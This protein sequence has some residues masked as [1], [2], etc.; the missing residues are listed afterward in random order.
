VALLAVT[1][2]VR[3]SHPS[4]LQGED[5]VLGQPMEL[6]RG[7]ALALNQTETLAA[8]RRGDRE[9]QCRLGLWLLREYREQGSRSS[10]SEGVDWLRQAAEGGEP[11]AQFELGNLHESGSGVIQDFAEA[12]HWYREAAQR[13]HFEAM[14]CLGRLAGLGRGVQK[15]LVDAY[16]W[17][18]VAAARGEARAEPAR[19]RVG[20]LLS[21]AE[22]AEAQERSR[23][24]HA[25]IPS[26]L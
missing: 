21:A 11:E 24:L 20:A 10:L 7:T 26:R 15:D 16:A 1:A 18:N 4:S 23:Q 3:S 17:L 8:A 9:A 2:G 14:Y 25:S 12:A 13:G 19:D 22:L 5:E 6:P